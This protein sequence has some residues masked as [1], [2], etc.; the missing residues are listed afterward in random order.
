[1]V[2]VRAPGQRMHV[3]VV[4]LGIATVHGWMCACV[5]IC[6]VCHII[7]TRPYL[8]GDICVQWLHLGTNGFMQPTSLDIV[9]MT[10]M[11]ESMARHVYTSGH[12]NGTLHVAWNLTWQSL[13]FNHV[14]FVVLSTPCSGHGENAV[15][16]Y[17][18]T[19]RGG[20]GIDPVWHN[21]I[22]DG[23]VVLSY[24]YSS[25]ESSCSIYNYVSS[26]ARNAW[27][28]ACVSVCVCV[29]ECMRCKCMYFSIVL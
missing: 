12:I 6:W 19:T 17:L 21:C 13:P 9:T 4:I 26:I 2:H 8:Y 23:D 25:I 11:N 1:M 18:S 24:V 3:M 29:C 10:C 14:F 22:T 27:I 15:F 20:G 5:Y 16:D 28:D 7:D